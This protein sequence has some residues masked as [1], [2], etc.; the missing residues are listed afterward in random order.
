MPGK[1]SMCRQATKLVTECQAMNLFPIMHTKSADRDPKKKKKKKKKKKT[2]P[3]S[4]LD[5]CAK[6]FT[7]K[8]FFQHL[9]T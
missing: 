5:V 2:E 3:L 9:Q 1:A 4:K 7:A 6:P 8:T